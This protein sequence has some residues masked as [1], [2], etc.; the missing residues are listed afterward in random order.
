MKRAAAFIV[1]R[2]LLL[3]TSFHADTST[4]RNV[5]NSGMALQFFV[6]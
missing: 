3:R 5:Q 1:E 6:I 4:L 2:R